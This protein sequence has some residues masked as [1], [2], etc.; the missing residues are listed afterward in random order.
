[1][2]RLLYLTL[3]AVENMQTSSPRAVSGCLLR[4][5]IV[6]DEKAIRESLAMFLQEKGFEVLTAETGE[7]GLEIAERENPDIMLLDI[8]L[9]G[10]N[11]MEV[12]RKVR[13]TDK[14]TDV[15]LITAYHDDHLHA[16]ALKK[17]AC[18]YLRKPIDVMEFEATVERTARNREAGR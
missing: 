10:M 16:E 11:G 15:I 8:M 3:S 5:L 7:R 4:V 1:L 14:G 6:D 13:E 2:A 18:G 17:G 12:L 9:P